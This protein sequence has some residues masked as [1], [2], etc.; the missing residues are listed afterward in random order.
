LALKFFRDERDLAYS[1]DFNSGARGYR[2]KIG[3]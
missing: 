3:T 2:I 1:I